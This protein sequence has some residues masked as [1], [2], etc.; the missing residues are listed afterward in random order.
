ML[1]TDLHGVQLGIGWFAFGQLNRGDSQAPDVS[2]VVVTALLDD[3]W[4]H[5]VRGPN[6][7]VLLRREGAREL[8]GHAEVS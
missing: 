5:P 2:L 6:K 7:R 3:L 8:T 1:K 4:R